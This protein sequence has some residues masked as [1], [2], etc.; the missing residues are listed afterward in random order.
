MQR[1]Q[2]NDHLSRVSSLVSIDR[3]SDY[4]NISD[5]TRES[6]GFDLPPHSNRHYKKQENRMKRFITGNKAS[7]KFKGAPEPCRD[8]FIYRVDNA[9]QTDDLA[10]HLD[11]NNFHI[12][13]IACVSHPNSKSKSFRVTLPLSEFSYAFDESLWPS[14]VRVRKYIPPRMNDV[15]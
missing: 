8:L 11:D 13:N 10:A 9:T 1:P 7:G 2:N 14:G 5:T 3:Y 15:D 12:Q 4:S 6:V